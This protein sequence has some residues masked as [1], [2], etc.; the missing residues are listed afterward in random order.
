MS[1]EKMFGILED[2]ITLTNIC[3]Q[4]SEDSRLEFLFFHCFEYMNDF[5]QLHLSNALHQVT[6]DVG[7]M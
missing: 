1:T 7:R 5:F 4:L 3:A 6:V 2:E